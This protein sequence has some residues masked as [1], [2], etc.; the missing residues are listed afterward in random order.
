MV[1]VSVDYAGPTAAQPLEVQLDIVKNADLYA[2]RL[3]ALADRE[4]AAADKIALAG[5]ADQILELRAKAQEEHGAAMKANADAAAALGQARKEA[6]RITDEATAKAATIVSDAQ[7]RANAI[8]A[9][10]GD[11]RTATE[12][13]LAAARMERDAAKKARDAAE[14][15]Q[16]RAESAC[17]AAADAKKRYFDAVDRMQAAMALPT[18]ARS[19][20][21]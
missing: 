11:A 8:L 20:T 4:A 6:S 7:D 14:L 12:A 16:S 10:A 9:A 2:G 19:L 5:A 15:A 17:V 13:A 21:P 3:K 18:E 1:G